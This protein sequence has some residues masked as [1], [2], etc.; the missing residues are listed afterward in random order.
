MPPEPFAG[1]CTFYALRKPSRPIYDVGCERNLHMTRS[2]FDPGG[3]ETER[4]GS[5]NLGP[6]ADNASRMPP[7][8]VDGEVEEE[9]ATSAGQ[10][11]AAHA[12]VNEVAVT[13][14]EAV[15]RL[16]AMQEQGDRPKAGDNEINS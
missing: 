4:S 1:R 3:G 16:K 9:E 14:D 6:A 7:D 15:A 8:V 12:N 5:R 2:I 11:D 13:D 10:T